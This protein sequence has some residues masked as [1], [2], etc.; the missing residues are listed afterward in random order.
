MSSAP[1][2]RSLGVLEAKAPDFSVAEAEGIASRIF[3][4]RGS[5]RAL[6]SERDQNFQLR[7]SDG[8]DYVL[9]IS[10]PAED[11]AVLDFQTQ[12]L[13]HIARVAPELPVPHLVTTTEGTSS[14][15]VDGAEGGRFITRLLSYLPGGVLGD[16]KPSPMLLRDVGASAAR[17]GQALRGFFHPAARHELPWDLTQAPA[18]R[19]R[20]HCI[21]DSEL[22]RRVEGVLDRLADRVLPLLE[23]MRAQVIH[24]DVSCNNTLVDGDRVV[25]VIDFGD[26]VHAPLVCDLVVPVAELI[27]EVDDPL[28][29]AMEI[30]AGYC[31]VEPLS[32]DEIAVLFDLVLARTAMGIA[33]SAWRVAD[34][35]ENHA[36]ITAGSEG[37]RTTLVWL[38]DRK[39]DFFH[40][41]LRVAGGLR[42]SSNAPRVAQWL[43]GH[44]TEMGPLFDREL[45]RLRKRVLSAEPLSALDRDAG[46]AAGALFDGIDVGLHPHRAAGC[47]AAA[48]GN[49]SESADLHLGTDLFARCGSAIHAPLAGVVHQLDPVEAKQGL[50]DLVLEHDVEGGIRF[51]TRYGNLAETELAGLRLGAPVEKGDQIG[52]VAPCGA[53]IHFQILTDW[54]EIPGGFPR[55]CDPDKWRVWR[56]LSPDPNA[57]LGIPPETFAPPQDAIEALLAR[58]VERLG[59][60]LSLFYDRPIHVVRAH[61]AW[62][63]DASGRALLDAYNNVPQ[64]GHCHPDVVEALSRQAATLNT[65]TRYI[66]GSVLEYSDR[67]VATMPGDLSVCM[68]VCSGSEANDLAWRLAKAHTGND[69]GIVMRDAYHGTTEAVND[70][71]P[72]ELRPGEA[73][74]PHIA[75]LQPPD[76]YRGPH[77]RDEPGYAERYADHLDDAIASLAERG[78]A[79]AA[80]YLDLILASSGIIKPPPGYL[81]AAFVKVRA[82]GGLCVADEVQS[83]FGRTGSHFWGFE[84]HGVIPDIVTLGKPIGNGYSMAAVVTT[85][86]IVRS[87][88]RHGEFFSTTGGNPVA[89]AVGLA[90]LDVLERERLQENADRVGAYLRSGL[91]SLSDRQPLIGDVRGAGLFIGVELVR[92]HATLDPAKEETHAVVNA[93]REDGVLVGIAG[94]HRNILKI[95]P[96]LVFSKANADQLI[97]ALD[98]ALGAL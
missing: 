88:V 31:A 41:C 54:I 35:P 79:P 23:G 18:L 17:L 65:N 47:A 73:P 45:A 84:G 94:R 62:L 59:P 27:V 63:I 13:L 8:R 36:Y 86:E 20:T 64:V 76:G 90:V 4:I 25:G 58:R 29:V 46:H 67:L 9:K 53:A 52:R 42:A 2:S 81:R 92:N 50:R 96:P 51:Y 40:A 37:S 16:A 68:F 7:A 1:D 11:P 91:E 82:A 95:R 93:M 43:S 21:E 85:P 66:F 55:V 39:A 75:L 26:M 32:A 44:A 56:D 38:M 3:G 33:I 24:N 60:G 71:S 22:R 19:A 5:A 72:A 12:A 34:H 57:I 10:N 6:V 80:F 28:G 97:A 14:C 77:R 61:G 48:T 30:A 87:L 78:H 74:A 98:R 83:G 89:C 15:T 70:L 69:G 49:P